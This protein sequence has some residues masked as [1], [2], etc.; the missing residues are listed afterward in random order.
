M[1][2]YSVE[3]VASF[4]EKSM[5]LRCHFL[6]SKIG[7][8]VCVCVLWLRLPNA[9]EL[10]WLPAAERYTK[11]ANNTLNWHLRQNYIYTVPRVCSCFRYCAKHIRT[12]L[13]KMC[14]DVA[15]VRLVEKIGHAHW[16]CNVA[17]KLHEYNK[18]WDQLA[19]IHSLRPHRRSVAV[20]VVALARWTFIIIWPKDSP[21]DVAPA[22]GISHLNFFYRKISIS[23]NNILLCI[24]GEQLM[25]QRSPYGRTAGHG[26]WHFCFFFFLYILRVV[27]LASDV[28]EF[29]FDSV[30][31]HVRATL[32]PY[33]LYAVFECRNANLR[34]TVECVRL[35]VHAVCDRLRCCPLPYPPQPTTSRLHLHISQL[36]AFPFRTN[37]NHF[38]LFFFC[39]L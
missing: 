18:C 27:Y 31:N 24:D 13:C 28:H 17:S 14:M 5:T 30:T 34:S 16:E 23:L 15:G 2:H 19:N 7:L 37:R 10:S 35:S 38:L 33:I 29:Q 8:C 12:Q 26:I 6:N 21:F 3:A 4:T 1:I 39:S 22:F 25:V 32:W 9:I 20:F 11:W 36:N